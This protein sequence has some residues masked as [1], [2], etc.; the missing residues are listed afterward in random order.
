MFA[1]VA[2]MVVV[3]TPGPEPDLERA[4]QLLDELGDVSELPLR[5]SEQRLV[6]KIRLREGSDARLSDGVTRETLA[7]LLRL[8]ERERDRRTALADPGPLEA[9]PLAVL[10]LHWSVELRLSIAAVDT[11]GQLL[12][13]TEIDLLRLK[14]FGFK[15]LQHVRRLLW[16]RA[17]R[18]L[19]DSV[20][21]S[22][23]EMASPPLGRSQAKPVLRAA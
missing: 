21:P 9:K 16:S 15:K 6:E 11:V 23:E 8:L 5:P 22:P 1:G 10:G 3:E 19:R 12:E 4:A 18:T 7:N 13:R 2:L 17:G 14:F 20:P